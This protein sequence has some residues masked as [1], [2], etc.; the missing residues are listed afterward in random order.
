MGLKLFLQKLNKY[1]RKKLVKILILGASGSGKTTIMQQ[2]F[3]ANTEYT[4]KVPPTNGYHILTVKYRLDTLTPPPT[5]HMQLWD[6]GGAK[7]FRDHWSEYY[8]DVDGIVFVIDAS[9]PNYDETGQVLTSVL[10]NTKLDNVPMCIFVNKMDL[11][12]ARDVETV[13]EKL[14]IYGIFDR[15]WQIF[16]TQAL[17]SS[18]ELDKG[19][20]WLLKAIVPR[21]ISEYNRRFMDDSVVMSIREKMA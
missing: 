16:A 17:K 8:G 2:L 10:N 11:A 4:P 14:N 18:K 20:K 3:I 12:F 21:S 15:R 6:L 7:S 5:F 13:A 19:L 9:A 1:K